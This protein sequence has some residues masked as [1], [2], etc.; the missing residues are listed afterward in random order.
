MQKRNRTEDPIS[1]SEKKK[2]DE[3][4]PNFPSYDV[5]LIN[6]SMF[7]PMSDE[8]NQQLFLYF[9]IFFSKCN[10]IS[11]E[12]LLKIVKN[13]LNNNKI[14]LIHFFCEIVLGNDFDLLKL[15]VEY[16]EKYSKTWE[17]LILCGIEYNIM[18]GMIVTIFDTNKARL[19]ITGT[20]FLY[21]YTDIHQ[22]E[23][24]VT[25]SDSSTK[26]C[27]RFKSTIRSDIILMKNPDNRSY[28]LIQSKSSTV[29]PVYIGRGGYG[30]VIC[31]PDNDPQGS[32]FAVKLFN[33]MDDM[34]YENSILDFI[35]SKLP[36]VEFIQAHHGIGRLSLSDGCYS[37][38][39]STFYQHG[40]LD[41]FL[42]NNPKTNIFSIFK[43][44]ILG[45]RNIHDIGIVHLDIKARNICIDDEKN[46]VIIDFGISKPRGHV[47]KRDHVLKQ[48]LYFTRP[49]RPP[50]LTIQHDLYPNG[51]L[52]HGCLDIWAALIE[53]LKSLKPDR[54]RLLE[55]ITDDS[56][57]RNV[58]ATSFSYNMIMLLNPYFEMKQSIIITRRLYNFISAGDRS[59][60][61][62]LLKSFDITDIA[63]I[64]KVIDIMNKLKTGVYCWIDCLICDA[65]ESLNIDEETKNKMKCFFKKYLDV[66]KNIL[67]LDRKNDISLLISELDEFARFMD[68]VDNSSS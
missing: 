14:S 1:S 30:S 2:K 36:V 61:R 68:T 49:H 35:S 26:L 47:L 67:G 50:I 48:D 29:K 5:F 57:L 15:K 51:I 59:D 12:S 28:S 37:F 38:I 56:C 19:F 10:T 63:L 55:S 40:T 3:E 9:K 45:L 20:R 54:L 60:I 8:M 4:S 52:S 23:L 27:C 17:I 46:P 58:Y 25:K 42:K 34:M 22:I 11:F 31:I 24:S 21:L 39:V 16:D 43:K 41:Q 32:L 44:I 7:E 66:D 64:K 18:I 13:F 62:V 65:L 53:L 33:R 6:M